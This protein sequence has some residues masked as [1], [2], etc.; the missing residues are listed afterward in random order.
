M[1]CIYCESSEDCGCFKLD[2]GVKVHFR[3]LVKKI[4][5]ASKSEKDYKRP[6]CNKPISKLTPYW[7]ILREHG[8]NETDIFY[9]NLSRNTVMNGL[10]R[11]LMETEGA[12]LEQILRRTYAV[13]RNTD[14]L[15]PDSRETYQYALMTG[16]RRVVKLLKQIY[17]FGR[18]SIKLSN[19]LFDYA[20]SQDWL[21]LI[22]DLSERGSRNL[23]C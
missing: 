4:E 10:A 3:C 6:N 14:A 11:Y 7:D 8:M 13:Y 21:E 9:M 17:G 5:I 18:S 12:P 1:S 19:S 23:R 16:D 20:W 2:C 15:F 22:N